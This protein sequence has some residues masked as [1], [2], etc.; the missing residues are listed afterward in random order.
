MT[1]TKNISLPADYL[2]ANL[3][4]GVNAIYTYSRVIG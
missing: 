4:A 3:A 2:T 1:K